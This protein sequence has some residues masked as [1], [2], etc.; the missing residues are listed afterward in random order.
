M[1]FPRTL[2]DVQNLRRKLKRRINRARELRIYR[3]WAELTKL[4]DEERARIRQRIARF[5][6]RPLI[7]IVLPVYNVEEKWLR[8]CIES[9]CKQLYENWELCIADDCS[10]A[11]HIKRILNEY[12]EKDSRIKIVFRET[13]GHISAASNSALALA[14]GEFVALLDH[15]DELA[16]D[17][18]YRVAAEINRFPSVELIYTD[19]DMIDERGCRYEPKFKPDWSPDLF[20][21]LNL[22]THL[23]VY[24]RTNLQKI[25]GFRAG[26]EGSQDYDLTLRFIEQINESDIRHIPRVLY[27]WRAIPGSV[28]LRFDQK[29][30]AH[31][32]AR[33]AIA[34]HLRRRGAAADVSE[35]KFNYHRVCYE[36]PDPAPLVSVIVSALPENHVSSLIKNV[37]ERSSYQNF[38]IILAAPK[39]ERSYVEK[40]RE[41]FSDSRWRVEV[42]DFNSKADLLNQAASAARG[43]ILCFFDC[44][45]S[46][47]SED[48]LKE[49]ISHAARPEIGVAGAKLLFPGDSL[50]HGGYIIGAG[51]VLANANYLLPDD[52]PGH[53]TRASVVQNVSAVSAAC[54][55]VK[56]D[57]FNLINGFDA[58]NLPNKLFDADFCL[59]LGERG[60][61]TVLTPYAK[62]EWQIARND[63][64]RLTAAASESEKRYFARRWQ[65]VIE[66]DPYYNPN[67]S[68]EN[69]NF[70]L[71]FPPFRNFKNEEN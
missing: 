32:A 56:R 62:L 55:A 42:F 61:R 59:R 51:D 23:A 71:Q 29:N 50:Q 34:E 14:S 18:L 66:N 38:E 28:A 49:L 58:E 53:L 67:F 15:D 26:F 52:E 25:G 27:H 17:A 43:S 40:I 21:S 36:I 54:L 57:L 46:A 60:L 47:V 65:S 7:S 44:R 9:V 24:R 10:P 6:S 41:L 35:G 1:K 11:P 4:S 12:R 70:V 33:K 64:E 8:L 31:D 30:Y 37:F 48:W 13:N 5:S 22:V 45:L 68:R 16:E 2:K 19:E 63:F 39:N 3:Q 69:G 20:Y